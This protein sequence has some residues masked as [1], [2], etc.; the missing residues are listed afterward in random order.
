MPIINLKFFNTTKPTIEKKFVID[1]EH[2]K[3]K[4]S[5]IAGRLIN[6]NNISD[7]KFNLLLKKLDKAQQKHIALIDNHIKF[8]KKS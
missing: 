4:A 5:N 3:D 2:L 7:S 6:A 1:S 8:L